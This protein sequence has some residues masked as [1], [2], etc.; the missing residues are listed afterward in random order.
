MFVLHK[1][2]VC[3]FGFWFYSSN[4]PHDKSVLTGL[5]VTDTQHQILNHSYMNSGF[6]IEISVG[7]VSVYIKPEF[8]DST[9]TLIQLQSQ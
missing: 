3:M 2:E 1:A 5:L 4:Q 6:G 9:F 8:A 7:F